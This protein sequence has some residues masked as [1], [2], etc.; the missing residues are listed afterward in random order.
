MK[1]IFF[2]IN[3]NKTRKHHNTKTSLKKHQKDI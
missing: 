2:Y 1:V 3:Q